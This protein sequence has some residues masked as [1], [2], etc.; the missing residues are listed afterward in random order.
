VLTGRIEAEWRELVRFEEA[1]RPAGARAAGV[2]VWRR[3]ALDGRAVEQV[4]RA[5][6][7]LLR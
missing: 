6:V 1:I 4:M 3:R 2:R 5:A 7:T